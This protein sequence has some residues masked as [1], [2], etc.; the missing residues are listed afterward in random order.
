MS[1]ILSL[2][3]CIFLELVNFMFASSYYIELIAMLFKKSNQLSVVCSVVYDLVC[4]YRPD[5]YPA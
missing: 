3:H 5:R 1:T 4:Y 2:T